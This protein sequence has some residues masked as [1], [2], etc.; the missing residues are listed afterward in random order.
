MKNGSTRYFNDEANVNGIIY[1]N[2]ASV[3]T[4]LMGFWDVIPLL[5]NF[6]NGIYYIS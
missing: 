5:K 2:F 4:S 6:R 1:S 3:A